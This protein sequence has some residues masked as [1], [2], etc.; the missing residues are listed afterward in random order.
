MSYILILNEFPVHSFYQTSI[1][2][3]INTLGT[4][5]DTF[6]TQSCMLLKRKH[7]QNT[8]S[9]IIEMSSVTIFEYQMLSS[10]DQV[11]T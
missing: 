10:F 2:V 1:G 9:F 11:L 7:G 6:P 3:G 8:R 4:V 5:L